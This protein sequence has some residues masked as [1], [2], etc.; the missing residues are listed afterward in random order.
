VYSAH[1][2][3]N[4]GELTTP[5]LEAE[6]PNPTFLALSPDRKYL[7]AVNEVDNYKGTHN[8]SLVSYRRDRNTG[9][10][11][12]VNAVDSEGSGPC[13]LAVDQTGHAVITANYNSGSA[14]S[15]HVDDNGR[16][17]N[18]VSKF[19]YHGRS[20]DEKRQEGPHAH[21]VTI[22]PDNRFVLISDLGL[23][24]IHVYHLTPSTAELKPAQPPSWSA[25]PGS[26]PRH[27]VFHPNHRIVYSTN[28]MKSTVD[29]LSWDSA[30]GTLKTLQTVSTLP[31]DFKQE[32]STAE[33]AVDSKGKF[34]YV[35]NRGLDSIAVFAVDPQKYT[36][37]LIANTPTGGKTPRHFTLDP[38]EKWLLAAN[39][40]GNNIVILRRDPSNG[41]L[42]STGKS[43]QIDAAVCLLFV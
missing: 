2:N 14:A 43:H 28:E 1:F 13:H 32:N 41:L 39:Q 22:S 35:S 15:Y 26:G 38:T 31:P 11:N 34:A 37:K 27:Q 10:L 8:G 21:C 19:Q 16:L 30:T 7:Y 18:P 24:K 17:S 20:A 25:A 12:E 33:I 40:D 4:T 23:D 36:L 3:S 6:T 29:V 42:S 5:K 9:Q